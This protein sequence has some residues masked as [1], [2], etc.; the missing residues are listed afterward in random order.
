M[1]LLR[2]VLLLIFLYLIIQMIGRILFG[3]GRRSASSYTDSRSGY[4]NRKEG[5]VYVDFQKD[6]KKKVIR[7]DEGEY[8]KYEELKD[9]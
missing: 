3:V 6:K 8:I 2:I 9:E 1:F 5:N 4:Q 7:K